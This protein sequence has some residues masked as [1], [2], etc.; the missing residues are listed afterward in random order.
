MATEIDDG[1]LQKNG[2]GGGLNTY[3]NDILEPK[4][5]VF[6]SHSG[7]Q[8]D[9]AEQL[10]VDLETFDRY[11]FFDKR[12]SSL[13]I[14]EGFVKL[15]F[16]AIQQCHIGV[17]ILSKDFFTKTKWPMIELVAMVKELEKPDSKI[18]I[19]PVFYHISRQDYVDISNRNQWVLQWEEWA[20]ED[21]RIC[22]E[23]WKIA[24][25]VLKG[26]N[27]LVINGIGE[28]KARKLIVDAVCELL[29]PE[30]RWDDSHVEGKLRLCEVL[31]NKINEDRDGV[32]VIGLYGMGGV[33]KT[34]ICR[35]MCNELFQ[36]FQGRVHHAELENN[37]G[38]GLLREVLKKFT[39][40][41]HE[42]FGGL[43]IDQCR[44]Q[45]KRNLVQEAVFL[46][47]DNVSDNP[48]SITNAKT[49]LAAKWAKGS[50]IIVTA[51]SLDTL[52]LLHQY[53]EAH[54]CIEM[55]GLEK[56]EAKSLFLKHVI[57]GRD[58]TIEMDEELVKSCVERCYFSKGVGHHYIPLALKVLG[59]QLGCIG[60]DADRWKAQL[61]KVETFELELF[62]TQH[63]IFSILRTSF[64][65]LPDKAQM[66]FMDV[67]LFLPGAAPPHIEQYYTDSYNLF[68]W[69][70]MVHGVNI[71]EMVLRMEGLKRKS[72][73]E[74]IGDGTTKVVMHDL[75]HEFCVAETKV[76]KFK[77]RRWVF[78]EEA[79]S[80]LR[81][82]SPPGRCWEHLRR[83]C[84]LNEG[85]KGLHRLHLKD[86]LN[87]TVLQLKIH[88]FI[89]P[90]TVR[91]DLRGLK[92]LKSL[93]VNAGYFQT[94][95]VG[96]GSLRNLEF[97][98]WASR[99]E[100]SSGYCEEIGHLTKLQGLAVVSAGEKSPDVSMMTSL[101]VAVLIHNGKSVAGLS[102][103]LSNLRFLFLRGCRNL[104]E[105][106]GLGGLYA[107]EE[108]NLSE[109]RELKKVPCLRLLT[110]LKELN[111]SFCKELRV[112][113][114]LDGLV[115]LERLLA[116]G[117]YKLD[118]LPD[119]QKV[120]KLERLECSGFS[121][122]SVLDIGTFPELKVAAICSCRALKSVT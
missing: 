103:K 44:D 116:L 53:I 85:W 98:T 99:S 11:P 17:L 90:N 52:L 36:E 7:A 62:G 110:L 108:L 41:R 22:V 51:R 5:K 105:C 23:E 118:S 80:E 50:V 20:N 54:N 9:F 102:S 112:V 26:I 78:L 57:C 68:D 107:L 39:N 55:P 75:W 76:G 61:N 84:F 117:C 4:H 38:V 122:M 1:A 89:P 32:R 29:L 16:D 79:S 6:L 92:H 100:A 64:D 47:I 35:A 87:V 40:K 14:G 71:D 18:K 33:G 34:T 109:C 43:Q 56:D 60:Y 93:E 81:E 45:L 86:F 88:P 21:K 27:S 119:M 58:D 69:L 10:C 106:P 48:D 104:Q 77:D 82:V 19:I 96:L 28:V 24:L 65:S 95:C 2:V 94:K 101:R 66:L 3:S 31:C 115:A 63:P 12:R 121:D 8:K 91:F 74:K 111:I 42:V 73:I 13:P 120:T 72:L 25:A 49:Y 114:G 37:N 83:M 70:S 97:L 15:I 67:A 30:T 46:A 113:P 59:E